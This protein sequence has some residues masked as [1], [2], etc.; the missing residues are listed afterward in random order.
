MNKASSQCFIYVNVAVYLGNG[1]GLF[2]RGYVVGIN[3]GICSLLRLVLLRQGEIDER[4]S[5]SAYTKKPTQPK[6]HG[7]RIDGGGGVRPTEFQTKPKHS[8]KPAIDRA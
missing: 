2:G 5:V 4:G 7:L 1:N 3:D 8:T 6:L